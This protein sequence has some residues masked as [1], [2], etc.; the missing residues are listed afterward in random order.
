MQQH[1]YTILLHFV[2]SFVDVSG[3]DWAIVVINPQCMT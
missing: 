2:E 1:F 3:M